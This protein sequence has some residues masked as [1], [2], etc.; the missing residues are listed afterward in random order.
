MRV[1]PADVRDFDLSKTGVGVQ[2]EQE[3]RSMVEM[4]DEV[5]DIYTDNVQFQVGPYDLSLELYKRAPGVNSTEPPM[6][7]GTVRMSHQHAKVLAIVLKDTLKQL[8]A[9]QG[10]IPIHPQVLNTLKLSKSE[11]W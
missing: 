8:E 1:D 5:P 3:E 2:P 4:P 9:Q 6:R 10:A 11:D 7:V